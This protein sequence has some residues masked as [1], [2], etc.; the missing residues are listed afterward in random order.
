MNFKPAQALLGLFLAPLL[1]AGSPHADTVVLK[2]KPPS[3]SV[4]IADFGDGRPAL[5][6]V[7]QETLR[8]RLSEIVRLAVVIGTLPDRAGPGHPCRR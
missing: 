4:R 7:S 5:R 8:K 6:G 1:V 3:R 2:G